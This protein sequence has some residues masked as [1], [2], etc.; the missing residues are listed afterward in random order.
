MSP[1]AVRGPFLFFMLL[2]ILESWLSVVKC[3]AV[4]VIPP[5]LGKEFAV[6]R[7]HSG[8]VYFNELCSYLYAE[9]RHP[10]FC[11]KRLEIWQRQFNRKYMSRKVVAEVA[12]QH[13][14][15]PQTLYLVSRDMFR[16][17]EM[18]F[19][20][21]LFNDALRRAPLVPLYDRTSEAYKEGIVWEAKVPHLLYRVQCS[22]NGRVAMRYTVYGRRVRDLVF[23]SVLHLDSAWFKL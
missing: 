15:D 20:E 10:K 11:S 14:V 6:L 22:E 5:I 7:M 19:N 17:V 3:S 4:S 8:T 9:D 16:L 1:L 13:G 18:G 12:A 23:D 21:D 2:G